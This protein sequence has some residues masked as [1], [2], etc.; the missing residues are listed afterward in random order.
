VIG[1][2]QVPHFA[3]A[4]RKLFGAEEVVPPGIVLE[5]DRPEYSAEKRERLVMGGGTVAIS[6]GNFSHLAVRV[7]QTNRRVILV[8]THIVL[9]AGGAAQTFDIR[10]GQT[11][12]ADAALASWLFRD[13]V[14]GAPSSQLITRVQAAQAGTSFGV[15]FPVP[16]NDFRVVP[17]PLVL[18]APENSPQFVAVVGTAVATAITAFFVGYEKL[19]RPEQLGAL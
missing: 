11:L 15:P 18:R 6:A 8:V 13:Q 12:T 9:V 3:E 4:V 5:M 1:F 19:V 14:A 2:E 17:F 10:V 16:A 7:N